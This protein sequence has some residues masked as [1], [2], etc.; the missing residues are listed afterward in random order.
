[1]VPIER[2]LETHSERLIEGHRGRIAHLRGKENLHLRLGKRHGGYAI[3][4]SLRYRRHTWRAGD[5]SG[6]VHRVEGALKS[7]AD[8]LTMRCRVRCSQEAREA[9]MH[10]N[11]SQP[12]LGIEQ[13]G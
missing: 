12:K 11:A 9:F 4:G 1:R 5:D 8:R 10:V 6:L 7:I 13:T 2:A 3:Q